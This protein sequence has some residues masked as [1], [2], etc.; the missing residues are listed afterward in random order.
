MRLRACL[1]SSRARSMRAEASLVMEARSSRTA[2]YSSASLA[3]SS[4]A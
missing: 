2:Q 4:R 1:P 3:S